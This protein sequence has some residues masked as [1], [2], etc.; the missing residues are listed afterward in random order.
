MNE[1]SDEISTQQMTLGRLIRLEMADE[2]KH[3]YGNW[4]SEV[5]WFDDPKKLSM[6]EHLWNEYQHRHNLIWNLVF[7]LTAAVVLLAVIPYTQKNVMDT[8]GAWILVPPILGVGLGTLVL[9]RVWQELDLLD[10]IRKLYRPLQDSLF[11]EFH[12]T[13]KSRI[14]IT[15]SR[16]VRFYLGALTGLAVINVLVV[17]RFWL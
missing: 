4:A 8:I 14:P 7:R 15:F 1:R 16:S 17:G 12:K 6:A 9:L 10:H 11:V 2:N 3:M 5:K 13:R